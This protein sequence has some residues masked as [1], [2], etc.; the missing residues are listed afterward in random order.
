MLQNAKNTDNGACTYYIDT[1]NNKRTV[2][3]TTIFTK[4]EKRELEDKIVED[5]YRIFTNK[6]N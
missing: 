2:T 4:E 6:A 1:A 5:L 3:H